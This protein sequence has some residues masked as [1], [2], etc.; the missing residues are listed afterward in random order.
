MTA[1]DPAKGSRLLM[2]IR[3]SLLFPGWQ[4]CP[5]PEV[6]VPSEQAI[7]DKGDRKLPVVAEVLGHSTAPV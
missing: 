6:C 3:L 2:L 7:G 1:P 5:E 4:S